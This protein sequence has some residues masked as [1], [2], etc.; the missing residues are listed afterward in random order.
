MKLPRTMRA[1]GYRRSL[2]IVEPESLLDLELPTPEARDRDLLVAVRAVSVN[3]VDV[4]VRVRSQ[5]EEGEANV[6]GWDAAGVVVATG[7]EATLFRPGDAVFYAGSITR[8]GTNA[9]YHLVDERIVGRKPE[10]LS[11]AEAAAMPLTSI[12]AWELLFDRLGV[13][14]GNGRTGTLLVVGGAGGVG[15]VLIQL[16][17]RLTGL[18]VVA[19]AS[20]PETREW[21]LA[22]GAHAVIDHSRP[23]DQEL[24]RIGRPQAEYVAGLTQTDRHFPAIVEVVA[25]Q[26]KVGLID[27]PE[28][29]DV[30]LLKRKSASLHWELMFTRSLFATP[31]MEAQHRLLDEVAGLVD[32]GVLRTTL[33]ETMG[34]VT[35]ANLKRAHALIES[36]RAK[37]KVVLE[38]F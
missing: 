17:R 3:P 4:K 20:R 19:T 31:D 14:R 10:T 1:V 29:I 16:A 35:A 12:T 26:G 24:N 30:R 18:A 13:E 22:L 36:G 8:P 27:D 5:P 11:F 2:P 38:G 15:S 9:E 32:G 25:P 7:P 28:P 6:L 33:A 37:G 21:C 34:A 23:L